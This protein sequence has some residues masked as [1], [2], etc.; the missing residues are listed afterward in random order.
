MDQMTQQHALQLYYFPECPYCRKVLRTIE[1]L[2]IGD[3]I[4]LRDIHADEETRRTLVQVGGKQ[5]VPCLFIDGAPMYES[6]DISKWLTASFSLE[7]QG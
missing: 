2:G 1:A 4:D 3:A 7:E 6:D 5:Q